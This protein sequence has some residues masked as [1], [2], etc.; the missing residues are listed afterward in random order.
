VDDGAGAGVDEPN[1]PV[2]NAGAGEG[3]VPPPNNPP[4][5]ED[6]AGVVVV[7]NP[8]KPDVGAAD[9][10]DE[11]PNNPPLPP[12]GAGLLPNSPP[13]VGVGADADDPNPPKV[14]AGGAD[15]EPPPPPPNEAP[16]KGA[17]LLAGAGFAVPPKLNGLIVFDDVL[18]DGAAASTI[19]VVDELDRLLSPPELKL[20]APRRSAGIQEW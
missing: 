6:R 3:V 4:P 13:V 18:P 11:D 5:V 2:P 20:I 8:P 14:G 7:P 9:G 15:V 16:N 1:S 17:P 19:D 12:A 10:V